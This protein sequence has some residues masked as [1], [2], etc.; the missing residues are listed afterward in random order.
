MRAA[1]ISFTSAWRSPGESFE[2]STR[3][4][5]GANRAAIFS[6]WAVSGIAGGVDCASA[7]ESKQAIQI[8]KI[9]RKR[10]R[11][12]T[13]TSSWADG[14][15]HFETHNHNSGGWPACRTR[16]TINREQSNIP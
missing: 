12:F 11:I 6:S 3:M 4:A 5:V 10:L 7:D 2:V 8:K 16:V 14:N 1:S 13:V 15:L 9:E